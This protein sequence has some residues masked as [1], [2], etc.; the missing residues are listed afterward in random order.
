MARPPSVR[1]VAT[2]AI[3]AFIAPWLWSW[4]IPLFS[5][6]IPSSLSAFFP[7]SSSS[8]LTSDSKP[9]ECKQTQG[10]ATNLISLDPL[11]I[12]IEKFLRPSEITELLEAG[13]TSGFN[14]SRVFKDGILTGTPDRTSSSAG[15]PRENPTVQCVLDRAKQFLGSMFDPERDDIGPPQLV[16]YKQGERFNR[17]FDWYEMPQQRLRSDNAHKRGKGRTWNRMASI[18]AILEDDCEDGETWFPHVSPTHS[19]RDDTDHLWWDHEDGGLMFKPV[20]GNAI[21]WVN[22]HAN[23]TGDERVAHAGLPL[24]KGAKTAMNIWPRK[25]YE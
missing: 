21:F 10:Y 4:T 22:L 7:S 14:P 23:G 9:Y 17:H 11:V 13:Q 24:T 3:I 2:T 1:A 5:P 16:Q 12:Y 18:F 6:F 20:A 15:L 19:R 8:S 25:F